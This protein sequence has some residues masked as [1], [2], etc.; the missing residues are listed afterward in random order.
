MYIE[1]GELMN[2]WYFVDEGGRSP[3]KEFI[4]GFPLDEQVKVFAYN[5]V[6]VSLRRKRQLEERKTNSTRE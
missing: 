4:D 2:I 6:E 5:D 1:Y 3:V